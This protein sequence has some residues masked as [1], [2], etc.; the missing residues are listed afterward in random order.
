MLNGSPALDRRPFFV[1]G[2]ALMLALSF[3]TGATWFSPAKA[4]STGELTAKVVLRKSATKDSKALQTLPEGDDVT[5][6]STSGSWY[7][8]N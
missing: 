3:L 6:L 5:I 4:E 2:A 1:R 7:R 8:I